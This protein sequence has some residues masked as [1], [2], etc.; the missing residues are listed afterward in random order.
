MVD[1]VLEWLDTADEPRRSAVCGLACM[2]WHS[3]GGLF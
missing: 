2:V 3:A 1:I